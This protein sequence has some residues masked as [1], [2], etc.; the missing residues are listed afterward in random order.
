MK[1]I[2]T[3]LSLLP[4]VAYGQE[5]SSNTEKLQSL[6][7]V[8]AGLLNA[9]AAY[10]VPLSKE[11]GL[12]EVSFGVGGIHQI[13]DGLYSYRVGWTSLNS[14]FSP[15]LQTQWRYYVSRERRAEKG[16]R[17]I[18]NAGSFVG[19]NNRLVLNGEI[20]DG[21]LLN[22]VVFG[23]QLPLDRHFTFTYHVGF[24]VG[25]NLVEGNAMLMPG[26]GFKFGYAF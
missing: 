3:I 15:Y 5:L 7:K 11:K 23:Q 17:L 6:F 21:V 20:S 12:L 18:N 8:E 19:L 16:R 24:G 10:E 1:R 25:F 9:N 26:L 22:H 13:E 14:Y 4:L 2:L